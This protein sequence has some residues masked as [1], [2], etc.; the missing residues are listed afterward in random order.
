[1]MQDQNKIYIQEVE[2]LKLQKK[3]TTRIFLP[4]AYHKFPERRFPVIYMFDG[5]NIFNQ[6]TAYHRPWMVHRSINK[7]PLKDQAIIV[8]IDNGHGDRLKEYLPTDFGKYQG[9]GHTFI[10]FIIDELKPKVDIH[11]RTLTTRN[12]TYIVGSSMGGLLAF[13]AATHF[14]DTFGKAGVLSPAFWIY[15]PIYDIPLAQKSKIYIMGSRA[16]SRTMAA[17]IEKAYWRLK[18]MG[19][20]DNEMYVNIKDKGKHSEI[21][22]RQAFTEMYKWLQ[23]D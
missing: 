8:G 14:S 16:E 4:E 13:Y 1:M 9:V 19:Y 22:W 3:R 5:Q 20:D 23:Q 7:L 6:D 11:L 2:M 18:K 12:D 10:Q 21:L 15:P 17:T